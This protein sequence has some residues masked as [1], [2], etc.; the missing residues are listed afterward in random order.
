ML[1]KI[2]GES[3]DQIRENSY[4][5]THNRPNNHVD[6]ALHRALF[7]THGNELNTSYDEDNKTCH[8]NSDPQV[9]VDDLYERD[10][11]S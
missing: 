8:T 10:N 4:T 7:P 1:E 6:G 5:E 3:H 11:I 9:L 2:E